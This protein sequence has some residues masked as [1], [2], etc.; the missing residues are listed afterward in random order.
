MKR[1]LCILFLFFYLL[2]MPGCSQNS[3]EITTP[4]NFYYRNAVIEF[5]GN[6]SVISAEIRDSEIC[7]GDL[8]ALISLYLAGPLSDAYISPF[9][10]NVQVVNLSVDGDAVH[11]VLSDSFAQ[12]KDMDLTLA[13]ACL[14]R[15]IMDL[16]AC[17]AVNISAAGTLLGGKEAMQITRENLLLD[18]N[19]P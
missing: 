18:R 3:D 8:Q 15:T 14:A 9:P 16:T 12:L 1:Y 2:T 19:L 5:N 11:I 13:C 17:N 10:Q 7:S 6:D 4:V